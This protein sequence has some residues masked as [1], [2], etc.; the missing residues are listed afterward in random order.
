MIYLSKSIAVF[1]TYCFLRKRGQ[2]ENNTISKVTF[3]VVLRYAL[4]LY[5]VNLTLLVA[6]LL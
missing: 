3:F 4:S 2:H 6:L 1:I 5:L